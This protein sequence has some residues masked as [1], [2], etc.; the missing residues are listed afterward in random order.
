MHLQKYYEEKD[1]RVKTVC[2]DCMKL[3]KTT[4]KVDWRVIE[5]IHYG[6]F[7]ISHPSPVHRVWIEETSENKKKNMEVEDDVVM[8]GN[9]ASQIENIFSIDTSEKRK[10]DCTIK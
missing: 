8:M 5:N 3:W 4:E 9:K 1:E 10:M 2:H 6:L 7:R